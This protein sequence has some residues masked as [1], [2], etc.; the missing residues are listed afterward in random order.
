MLVDKLSG[1]TVGVGHAALRAAPRPERRLAGGGREQGGARGDQGAEAVRALVH[2]PVGRGQVDDRQPGRQAPA[3]R[4]PPHLPAGRRQRPPRPEPRPRLH[5]RRSRREHPPHRRGGEADGRRRADRQHRV[6]LAVPRRAADGARAGRRRASSSRSSSTRRWPSP[7]SAIRRGFT[8]RRGVAISRTSP[9]SIRPTSAPRRP[10]LTI[11]TT[12][13]SPAEAAEMVVAYLRRARLRRMGDDCATTTRSTATPTACARCSSCASRGRAAVEAAG[14]AGHRRQARHRAARSRRGVGVGGRRVHGA[15][16]VAGREPGR[17]ARAAGE[18]ASRV[19]YFDHHFAGDIPAHPALEAHID[20]S[21][22]RLH[23]RCS[24][25]ATWKGRSGRWAIAGAFGDSLTD[26]AARW[27]RRRAR[28]RDAARAQGARRRDQLQ[29]LRRDHRRPARAAGR[30][31]GRDAARTRTRWS[32]RARRRRSD[33]WPTGS[34]DD[35]EQARRLEPWRQKRRARCVFVLPDA[36]W[37][38]RA[39]G[40]LAN[41]RPRR[42]TAA[43]SPSCRRRRRAAIW[44]RCACRATRRCRRRRSAAGFRRAA[45]GGRRRGSIICRAKSWTFAALRAEFRRSECS[46]SSRLGD[47]IQS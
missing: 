15:G 3:R 16:R 21:P 8:R 14:D 4:Q 12:A 44:F 24:S 9:A 36:A 39:S 5:R 34:A 38:R 7:S 27:P 6:H 25:I 33:G 43:R 31:C 47:L 42:T 1:A 18:R 45:G 20:L 29:R 40:T 17:A 22:E 35:M 30:A 37:A 46:N 10:E 41:D 28:R 23:Q 13:G 11:D 32:S 19:R 2:G 26:E